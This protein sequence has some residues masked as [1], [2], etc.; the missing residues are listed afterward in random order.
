VLPAVVG[1]L[2]GLI[3]VAA[4]TA[5][6]RLDPALVNLNL[7]F[8]GASAFTAINVVV[9]AYMTQATQLSLCMWLKALEDAQPAEP[10]PV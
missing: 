9:A 2:Y 8:L 5:L 4:Q 1:G 10:T 6:L 3:W 7:A